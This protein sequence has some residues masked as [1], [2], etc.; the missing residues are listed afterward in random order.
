M[1]MDVIQ[2]FKELGFPIACVAWLGWYVYNQTQQTRQDMGEYK[3][4][5]H[6]REERLMKLN[7]DRELRFIDT[8]NNLTNNVS[9]R[10]DNIESDVKDI[11]VL[12]QRERGDN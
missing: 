5:S 7:E 10:V 1:F 3:M 6:A 4:E 12:I 2:I 8:I 9:N 11:K